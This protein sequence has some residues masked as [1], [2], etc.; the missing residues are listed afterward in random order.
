MAI[1]LLRGGLGNQLFQ[2]CALANLS[3]K[4]NFHVLIT[5]INT[6]Y[7]DRGSGGA[8]IFD[9]EI[10][11]WF[12][13]AQKLLLLQERGTLFIRLMLALNKYLGFPKFLNEES[14]KSAKK[15]PKI[16]IVQDYFQSREYADCFSVEKIRH[17]VNRNVIPNKSNIVQI[18]IGLHMRLKDLLSSPN[19]YLGPGYYLTGISSFVSLRNRIF[20]RYSNDVGGAKLM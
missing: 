15:L 17:I 12:S 2:V 20:D 11:H 3:S 13:K 18:S 6:S 16:F 19:N 5:D 4:K 10:Y 8:E 9:L 1:L 14:L 7:L